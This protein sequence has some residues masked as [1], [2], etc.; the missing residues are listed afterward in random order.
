[1]STF[2]PSAEVAKVH[3]IVKNLIMEHGITKSNA[4]EWKQFAST[5]DTIRI[6]VDC[7]R[8]EAVNKDGE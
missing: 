5:L 7:K 8:E 4:K 1:M 2:D 6:I 3:R